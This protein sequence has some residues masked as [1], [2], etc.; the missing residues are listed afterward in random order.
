MMA[1]IAAASPARP[2][3]RS[4]R[5]C[6]LLAVSTWF[7]IRLAARVFRVGH[8]HV[9]PAAAPE[10]DLALDAVGVGAALVAARGFYRAIALGRIRSRAEGT[11]YRSRAASNAAPTGRTR[12]AADGADGGC[13]GP[14]RARRPT[15]GRGARRPSGLPVGAALVGRPR[16]AGLASAIT[17][18][19]TMPSSLLG[20]LRWRRRL[21]VMSPKCR[22]PTLVRHVRSRSARSERTT[23]SRRRPTVVVT[24]RPAPINS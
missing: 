1:R 12:W 4:P 14:S 23:T 21:A 22:L 11:S 24:I 18:P 15:I 3:G 17:K 8:P 2:P 9:R 13:E 19:L 10:G 5:A 7:A 20:A 16:L 6:C